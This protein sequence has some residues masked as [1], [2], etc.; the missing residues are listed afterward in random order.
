MLAAGPHDPAGG[1]SV[2][3][4]ASRPHGG[5]VCE[6]LAVVG[7]GLVGGSVALAARERRLAGEIRGVDPGLSHAGAIPLVSL[8]EAARWADLVVL[9]VPPAS[10]EAVLA[11]LAPFLSV[12]ALV[13]DTASVKQPIASAA[14]RCLRH[15]E[16]CVGAHPMAGSEHSGFRHAR[17]DLFEG[18]PCLLALSGSEPPEVV[19]GIERLWQGLGARTVHTTPDEHDARVALLSHVPHLIAYAFAYAF[20]QEP[21]SEALLP[22]AGK[23]LRDFTRIARASP[24]LWC[25]ILLMNRAAVAERAARFSECL[26]ETIAALERGDRMELERVLRR[27]QAAI[28]KLER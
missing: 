18:A 3:A 16:R 1:S 11:E 27:G 9:A 21:E 25:E 2:A 17:A 12:N 26:D 8:A 4:L 10:C 13:T 23:G 15:P 20:A 7:M 28:E 19:A 6:R 22:L 24:E 14:R 5:K